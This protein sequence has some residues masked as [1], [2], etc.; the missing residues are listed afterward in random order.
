MGE[1]GGLKI[2]RIGLSELIPLKVNGIQVYFSGFEY[3]RNG[4]N[5]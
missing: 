2:K 3:V 1:I 4:D 5:E